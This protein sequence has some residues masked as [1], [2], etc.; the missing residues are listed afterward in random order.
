MDTVYILY[1]VYI[2]LYFY[3]DDVVIFTGGVLC[4]A[5]KRGL[6]IT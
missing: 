5:K 6:E 4:K 2:M 1:T 3:M